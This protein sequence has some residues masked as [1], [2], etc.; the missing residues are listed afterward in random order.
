MEQRR[1][2]YELKE[3]E[4]LKAEFE[5]QRIDQENAATMHE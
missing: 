1:L 4:E 5:K 2:E 3:A